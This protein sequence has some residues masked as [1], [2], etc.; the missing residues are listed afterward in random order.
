MPVSRKAH[1]IQFPATP[2]LRTMSVTR[3]GVSAE[4]V[5]ATIE[6]PSS[7]HGILRPDRKNSDVPVPARFAL[8]RPMASVTT[9]VVMMMIQSIVSR[10]IEAGARV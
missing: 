7:H 4:N 5:V 9:K 6:I 3:F 2:F 8:Y 10:F 1:H